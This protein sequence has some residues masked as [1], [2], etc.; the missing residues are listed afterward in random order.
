MFFGFRPCSQAP[1]I[2]HLL[3]ADDFLLICRMRLDECS[4]ISE[5]LQ[6]YCAASGQSVNLSKTPI[7]LSS[8]IHK[9]LGKLLARCLR[10]KWVK[11]LWKYLGVP[12]TGKR[13]KKGDFED[14]L[15]RIHSRL[16]SWRADTLSTAG[17]AVLIQTVCRLCLCT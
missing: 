1:S 3:F 6:A 15:A 8:Y 7:R 13:L 11:G 4:A 10:M 16:G 17:R 9:R 2:S 12:V 5:M 14:L